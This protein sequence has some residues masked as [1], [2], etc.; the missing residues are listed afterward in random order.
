MRIK[1]E[2]IKDSYFSRKYTQTM[3]GIGICAIAI[4]MTGGKEPQW[5]YVLIG[6]NLLLIDL[7]YLIGFGSN[8][9]IAANF[10]K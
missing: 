10:A 6:H 7:I 1:G 2:N 4:I 8:D 3:I 5:G 9:L